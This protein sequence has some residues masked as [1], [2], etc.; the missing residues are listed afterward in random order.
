MLK[1]RYA[2]KECFQLALSARQ[3]DCNKEGNECEHVFT[4]LHTNALLFMMWSMLASDSTR[5][6]AVT[7]SSHPLGLGPVR[8]SLKR[9][10]PPFSEDC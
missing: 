4:S 5:V 3:M 8:R 10:H 6:R 7:V 9:A 1:T 2:K